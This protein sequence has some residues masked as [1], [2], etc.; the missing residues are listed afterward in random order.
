MSG[1]IRSA[2]AALLAT[3][4]LIGV[5][6]PSTAW[7]ISETDE[8][9]EIHPVADALFMRPLGFASLVVGGVVFIP[10]GLFTALTRPTE[11][12]TTWDALVMGPVRYTWLDPLGNHPRQ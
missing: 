8:S 4:F 10:A 6:L 7:A 3:S 12:G 2:I 1:R 5:C 9:P 11:I